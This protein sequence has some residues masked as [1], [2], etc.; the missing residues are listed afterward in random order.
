MGVGVYESDF[1]GTG[2][3]FIVSPDFYNTQ[4]DY[5]AYCKDFEREEGDEPLDFETWAQQNCDDFD[6]NLKWSIKAALDHVGKGF[7]QPRPRDRERFGADRDFALMFR[8]HDLDVGVRGWETDTIVGIAPTGEHVRRMIE[9][10][11]EYDGE[12]EAEFECSLEALRDEYGVAV[13]ALAEIII[14]TLVRDGVDVRF[15]TSGYTSAKYQSKEDFDFDAHARAVR[16][17]P[18]TAPAP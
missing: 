12:C 16:R 11:E 1:D 3:T 4:E 2:E 6:E 9:I 17:E 14:Q 7:H 18:D 13:S 10:G 15:K 5:E 8:G